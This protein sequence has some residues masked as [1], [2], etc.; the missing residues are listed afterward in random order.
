MHQRNDGVRLAR[1]SERLSCGSS[2]RQAKV[3][4]TRITG[5]SDC[6]LKAV[7]MIV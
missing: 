6:D 4:C 7:G 5:D 2:T 1:G 3:G